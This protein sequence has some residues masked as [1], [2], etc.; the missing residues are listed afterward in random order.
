MKRASS[1]LC[2]LALMLVATAA[3]AASPDGGAAS[4]TVPSS[5]SK[6]FA[7]TIGK[8]PVTIT[9]TRDG[10][11]LTGSYRY[12]PARTRLYRPYAGLS[13]EGSLDDR[14]VFALKEEATDEEGETSAS[15]KLAGTMRLGAKPGELIF[16]DGAWSKPDGSR[17]L[18]LAVRERGRSAAEER[19]AEVQR[20]ERE[21]HFKRI[22]KASYPQVRGASGTD[23]SFNADVQRL[24]DDQVKHYKRGLPHFE[25]LE[26]E[27]AKL[28]FQLTFEI[29]HADD[30]TVSLRFLIDADSGGAHPSSEVFGYVFNRATG[31]RMKLGDLFRRGSPY[32]RTLWA[33]IAAVA[34][35]ARKDLS[36]WHLDEVGIWFAFFEGHAMGDFYEV[37]V[38]YAELR[39]LLDPAGPAGPLLAGLAR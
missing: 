36:N 24:V 35:A 23:Q 34:P 19:L 2:S 3:V 29:Q 38:P 37:V 10:R 7:G 20:P 21:R 31:K 16:L 18:P 13:L 6:T 4:G 1:T 39:A 28:S 27:R 5:F 25:S 17:S 15:G 12:D 26:E 30:R 9:L 22:I 11:R 32:L 33:K 14:G 8:L